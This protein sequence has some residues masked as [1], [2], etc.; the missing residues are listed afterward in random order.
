VEVVAVDSDWQ[1]INELYLSEKG[2]GNLERKEAAGGILPL[3]VDISDPTPAAG[4][5]HA[6]RS[7]FTERMRADLVVALALVHHLVLGKNIPLGGVARYFAELCGEH[8]VI[9][10]VPLSDEK[11]QELVRPK[12]RWHMP[13]DAEN[14]EKIFGVYFQIGRKEPIPGT[15]RIL[16][17][18]RKKDITG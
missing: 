3:C 1:C 2:D 17:R 16:Y 9:E 15:E 14:F 18:M 11:A 12:S 5:R 8:L 6:E 7:S 4:F 10:F 13:Y